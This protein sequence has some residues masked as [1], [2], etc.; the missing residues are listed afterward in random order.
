MRNA[1]MHDSHKMLLDHVLLLCVVVMDKIKKFSVPVEFWIEI[2][3]IKSGM[4][5]ISV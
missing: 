1:I 3:A 5:P 4:E 2:R